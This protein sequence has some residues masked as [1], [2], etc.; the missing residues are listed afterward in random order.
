M[1]Q[2]NT[3]RPAVACF[4]PKASA[5]HQPLVSCPPSAQLRSTRLGLQKVLLCNA[6]SLCKSSICKLRL[7][8][9]GQNMVQSFV[10]LL[11]QAPSGSAGGQYTTLWVSVP[12]A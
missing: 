10:V 6:Q 4:L 5:A 11:L 12:S 9:S 2:G 1:H 7:S 8:P 3:C